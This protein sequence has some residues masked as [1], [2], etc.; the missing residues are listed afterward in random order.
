MQFPGNFEFP[1][2]FEMVV[3]TDVEF[4]PGVPYCRPV[5]GVWHEVLSG[6]TVRLWQDQLGDRP[7]FTTGG[8]SLFVAYN[9]QAEMGFYLALGW[10]LPCRVLDLYFEFRLRT[11]GIWPPKHHRRLLEALTFYNLKGIVDAVEKEEMR[12]LILR[13]P[14]WSS[15]ERSGI[16]EYCESDVRGT[17]ALLLAMMASH[18]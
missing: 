10:P 15:E 14:P 3:V 2:D 11:S 17:R 16:L 1:R 5:C 7:P 18:D 12:D 6:Q 9:A 13:G 8:N 4:I